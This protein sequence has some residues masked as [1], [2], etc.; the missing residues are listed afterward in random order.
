MLNA[1]ESDRKSNPT[2]KTSAVYSGTDV[3]QM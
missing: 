2:P 3:A 1:A